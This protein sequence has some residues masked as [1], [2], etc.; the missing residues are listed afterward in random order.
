M[1][2]TYITEMP[3]HI[4]AFLQASRCFAELNINIT[5]VS[6]NKAVDSHMLFIEAEGT[7]EQLEKADDLLEKIGYLPK[8]N[9]APE[10]LLIE[11][12]IQD[13]PGAVTD[14][15]EL[16]EKHHFNISYINSNENGTGYQLFKMGL[17]IDKSCG[18]GDFLEQAGK[19]CSVRVIDY[20]HSEKVFDNSIFY[21]SFISGLTE[22]MD[23]D[24]EKKQELLVNANNAMQL[25]DEKGLLP[26]KVFD[27][28]YSF[29][30]LLSEC[31]GDAFVPRI[32]KNQ[33]NENTAITLIE[34]ACGSNTVILESE[35]KY[36]FIDSGYACYKNEM[37][38]LFRELIPQFDNMQKEIIITH[39]DV[40][41]CGLL[42]MFDKIYACKKSAECLRLEYEKKDGFREQNLLHRPYIRMC[43]ILSMYNPPD[44]EKVIVPWDKSIADD[45]LLKHIG[46]FDFGDFHF[47]VYEGKG[48]HLPGEIVLVDFDNHIAFSGD[49]FVNLKDMIPEQKRY[50][51]YAPILMTSVDTDPTLRAEECTALFDM[52]GNKE[53]WTVYGAHGGAKIIND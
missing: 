25:L 45:M 31:R 39:A 50:N 21:H 43:K 48:G 15:L 2:K 5:R 29:T 27:S 23:I 49:I 42:P 19:L 13:V 35:G 11:F 22:M 40:D 20:N 52:L 12:R 53:K 47:K 18:I 3:N 34:P 26:Y 37:I 7:K 24:G 51:R 16:I 36:L 28:I 44:P 41:H 30:K 9:E 10:V 14:V 32:T 17:F 8:A 1:R 6:Y 46:V 38:K 4:G 33:I